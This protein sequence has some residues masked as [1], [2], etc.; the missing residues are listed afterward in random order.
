MT[1]PRTF[2]SRTPIKLSLAAGVVFSLL[3]TVAL[4]QGGWRCSPNDCF[5]QEDLINSIEGFTESWWATRC[6]LTVDLPPILYQCYVWDLGNVILA[7]EGEIPLKVS[8]DPSDLSPVFLG[9]DDAA[10]FIM[11]TVVIGDEGPASGGTHV[12]PIQVDGVIAYTFN[13]SNQEVIGPNG[14]LGVADLGSVESIATSGALFSPLKIDL[15]V[16]GPNYGGALPLEYCLV[17]HLP[18]PFWDSSIPEP[19]TSITKHRIDINVDT[20]PQKAEALVRQAF[21]SGAIRAVT[22]IDDTPD[23]GGCNSHHAVPAPDL[24]SYDVSVLLND[25]EFRDRHAEMLDS[26]IA[27]FRPHVSAR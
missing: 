13:P 15:Q 26:I 17:R 21:T 23:C 7:T 6:E 12:F 20:L 18:E 4:A 25:E 19:N 9:P 11:G 24:A 10:L 16:E 5:C 14:P 22:G 1:R 8:L 3:P 27:M 2:S